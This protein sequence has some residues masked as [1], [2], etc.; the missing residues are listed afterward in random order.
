MLTDG[1]ALLSELH[2][3]FLVL[4]GHF[5]AEKISKPT[6]RLLHD[7]IFSRACGKAPLTISGIVE[8][9][10]AKMLMQNKRKGRGGSQRIAIARR[11]RA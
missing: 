7:K 2:N 3:F 6:L 4:H 8:T 5:C 11:R 10:F 1:T 9:N